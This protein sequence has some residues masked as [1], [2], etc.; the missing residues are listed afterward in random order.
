MICIS[1]FI[2]RILLSTAISFFYIGLS[3]GSHP[4]ITIHIT[5]FG[6]NQWTPYLS[7]GDNLSMAKNRLFFPDSGVAGIAV[8]MPPDSI[9]NAMSDSA[10]RAHIGSEIR[11][12]IRHSVQQ[13]GVN[14]FEIQIVQ[15]INSVGY[16]DKVRQKMVDQ[17]GAIAYSAIGDVIDEI[18]QVEQKVHARAYTLSNGTKVLAA[19]AKNILRNGKPYLDG[20]DLLNGRAKFNTTSN[21]ISVL[22]GKNIRLFATRGD[23]P[24][25]P[26]VSIASFDT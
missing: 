22:G 2:T 25:L 8:P 14:S 10:L 26:K 6:I 24:G 17:F 9:M 3:Y 13:D 20:A 15:N 11:K 5:D 12:Q 7:I 1:H 18:K 21:L 23:L 4:T 19:N 16:S